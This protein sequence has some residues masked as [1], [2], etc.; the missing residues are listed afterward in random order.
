MECVGRVLF[1][2]FLA[3]N[4]RNISAIHYNFF[5]MADTPFCALEIFPIQD[6][7][8]YQSQIVE[9]EPRPPSSF[10]GQII[11]KSKCRNARV[12]KLWSREHIYNII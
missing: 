8:E 10:S 3:I 7:T 5:L 2:L 6:Y 9:F 4:L 11:I 12:T 1:L